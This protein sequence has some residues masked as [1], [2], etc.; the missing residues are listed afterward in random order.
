M[1]VQ[2]TGFIFSEKDEEIATIFKAVGLKTNTSRVLV[3]FLKGFDLTSREV[4]R[5]TDL[6]Q[7]EVS[8]AINDLIKR[9]WVRVTRHI[10]ENKGRPIKIYALS[11]TT[12]EIIDQIEEE[13]RTD[14]SRQIESIERV[15]VLV[16]EQYERVRE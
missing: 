3:M 15:R 4:E 5:C 7:P 13:I 14:Y 9:Q 16:K 10:T 12:D 1:G 2:R 11:L 6:R 8:I